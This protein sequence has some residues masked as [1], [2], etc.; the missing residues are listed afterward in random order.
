MVR[1]KLSSDL[2]K[3]LKSV[4]TPVA[5]HRGNLLFRAGEPVRGAFL[6]RR[7]QVRM[8]LNRSA[9]FRARTVGSGRIIG[10][11][12]T[13]SGEPYSLTA[14]ATTDCHLYFISRAM[15]LNLLRHNPRV[16]YEIIRILS[17]EI[18]QMRKATTQ[19]TGSRAL[20]S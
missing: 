6:I 15:M 11:P 10:L 1:E 14:E 19:I 2:V 12:A 16:G 17:K 20:S 13:F 8:R 18:F 4:A 7:G 3:Q 5:I 9:C